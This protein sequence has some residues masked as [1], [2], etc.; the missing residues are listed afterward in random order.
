M[1]G[2]WHAG[3]RPMAGPL[4]ARS[5]AYALGVL[6]HLFTYLVAQGYLVGNPWAAVQAP[7]APGPGID[8]GRA[9]SASQWQWV[10]EQLAALPLTLANRRLRV[11]LRLLYEA[12]PRLSE[13]VSARTGDLAWRS[14][15]APAEGKGSGPSAEAGW[16]LA[17]TGKGQ[18]RRQ[19]PVSDAWVAELG[20]YLVARGLPGDPARAPDAFVLGSAARGADPCAGISANVFHTQLT[21]FFAQCASAL[22]AT[23]PAG[24]ARLR[25]A[26]THWLRHT[27]ISHALDAGVPVQVA[28][29]NAG[30]ASLS[31]TTLYVTVEDA[32]RGQVLRRWWASE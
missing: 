2:R 32:R 22:A 16:W 19:V 10:R 5:C 12:G 24:A 25:Q 30:H 3:W 7:R 23:D 26:T 6:N 27:H 29:R 17:I 13:L 1:F 21:T 15:V 8:P 20:D 4:S 18:R 9:L 31:T 11:A 28:Q 14:L